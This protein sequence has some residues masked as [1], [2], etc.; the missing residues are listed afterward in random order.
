VSEI[1]DA[2]IDELTPGCD[3]H[4]I[5]SGPVGAEE[6]VA[7]SGDENDD[8][9]KMAQAGMWSRS[10]FG[11]QPEQQ[12]QRLVE[13]VEMN[14]SPDV[15]ISGIQIAAVMKYFLT[16]GN[17][18]AGSRGRLARWCLL[19]QWCSASSARLSFRLSFRSWFRLRFGFF[20]AD[21]LKSVAYQRAFNWKRR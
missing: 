4:V 20:S 14:F 17:K 13:H 8:Q 18:K 3:E 6:L 7:S 5:Q 9:G 10:S 2:R 15:M 21:F 19:S 12:Q 11:L 1:V 16:V